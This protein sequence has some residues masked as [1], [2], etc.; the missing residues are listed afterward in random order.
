MI[1][2]KPD[3]STCRDV[4][5]VTRQDVGDGWWEGR[6]ARGECGLFPEGVS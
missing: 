3:F 1:F 4:L 5:T 2:V 6:N